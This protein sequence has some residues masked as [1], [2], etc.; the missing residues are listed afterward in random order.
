MAPCACLILKDYSNE[1]YK[2]RNTIT[3]TKII[4]DPQS[5]LAI[6]SEIASEMLLSGLCSVQSPSKL[7]G[8]L[9][10]SMIPP[11]RLS[12]GEDTLESL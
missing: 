11:S 1:R 7:L 2:K 3:K 9:Q 6:A 8:R 4:I 10:F 5:I 12:A